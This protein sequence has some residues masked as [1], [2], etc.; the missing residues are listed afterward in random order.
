MQFLEKL[1]QLV[2]FI[3]RKLDKKVFHRILVFAIS[4]NGFSS[5]D[6]AD[7]DDMTLQE[8]IPLSF[9]S[10]P[11]GPIVGSGTFKSTIL[12]PGYFLLKCFYYIIALCLQH[13]FTFSENLKHSMWV[14]HLENNSQR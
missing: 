6:M 7:V 4:D 14:L 11:D 10:Q 12:V 1:K 5:I 8:F 9:Y 13:I 2:L 3:E